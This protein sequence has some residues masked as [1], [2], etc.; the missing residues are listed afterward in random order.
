MKLYRCRFC[1]HEVTSDNQLSKDYV[2]PICGHTGA[3]FDYIKDYE[4]NM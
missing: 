1:G 4:K 3:D 2:C